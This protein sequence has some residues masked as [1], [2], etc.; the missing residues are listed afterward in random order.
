M[1]RIEDKLEEFL[2]FV[3]T[4]VSRLANTPFLLLVGA[5]GTGKTHLFSDATSQHVA[6]GAPSVLLIGSQFRDEE[7]WAQIIRMF[8]LSCTRDEFLGALEAAAQLAGRRAVIFVDALN[9]G[10]G[11]KAW[12]TYLP[13]MLTTIQR[14]PWVALAVSVRNSYEELVVPDG[15]VPDK[16]TRS[17]HN[18]F[19][20]QEYEAAKAYFDFY[21]IE[22]PAV[23]I[24]TP[25]FQNPLFLRCFCR[26]LQNRGLTKIPTGIRG[27]SS[28]FNFF[29]DS[30]NEKLASPDLL[31]YDA[32]SHLV[33]KATSKIASLASKDVS[34]L[35]TREE[36]RSICDT[37]LPGRPYELSLFRHLLS[38]GILA[39]GIQYGDSGEHEEVILFSYERLADHL[40]MRELIAKH[41]DHQNPANA[42]YQRNR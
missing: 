20:D 24:L 33:G 5:A 10:S 31:D 7:P 39:E 13:S 19:T 14:F 41:V 26:G 6:A 1:Q 11:R 2:S 17:V 40:I 8:G 35:V 32:K 34:S 21:G 29:L 42:L 23:P 16:M 27:I 9:E 30:V 18:G 28:V 36:T 37:L 15:L 3:E 22:L 38:E 4:E 12:T 25:E